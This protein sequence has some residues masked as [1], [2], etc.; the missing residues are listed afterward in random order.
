M[1]SKKVFV[2]VTATVLSLS[3]LAGCD[4]TAETNPTASNQVSTATTNVSMSENTSRTSTSYI[5]E[6]EA[7]QIALTHAGVAEEDT[8]F[9]YVK[10]DY[11]DGRAEYDVEFFAGGKEYDYEIDAST[12]DIL[13]SDFDAEHYSSSSGLP[14]DANTGSYI[15]EDKAKEIALN[16]AG[17]SSESDVTFVRVKLD[18]DNGR[19]EYD[20]EFYQGNTEYDY[21]ID[22]SNGD[23]LSYDY[24]AEYYSPSSTDNYIGDSQAK[25]IALAHAGL[26]EDQVTRLSVKLDHDDGRAEYEVEFHVGR[27]EYNYDID[28]ANGNILSYE[29]D[30]D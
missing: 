13:S 25:S 16:H 15:G 5:T 30:S 18:Y 3:L 26:S 11:D 12:G 14:S 27:T 10:Q 4:T 23:I 28:A 8:S 29:K 22:A 6:E 7:K 24:D 19:A 17:L 1:K 20:V 2:L 9:L 21:E